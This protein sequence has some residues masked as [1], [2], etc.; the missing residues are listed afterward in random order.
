MTTEESYDHI[1]R[2][3]RGELTGEEKLLFEKELSTNTALAEGLRMHEDL[4]FS[5]DNNFR[6]TLLNIPY[7]SSDH[8]QPGSLPKTNWIQIWSLAASFLLI[9][10]LGLLIYQLNK[11]TDPNILYA[12]YFKPPIAL[13]PELSANRGASNPDGVPGSLEQYLYTADRYYM[14]GQYDEAIQ[15]LLSYPNNGNSQRIQFQL[16][17]L[18]LA[19]D[20]PADALIHFNK[21]TQY[22][23]ADN[24]WYKSLTLL[25]LN[26]M[27]EAKKELQTLVSNEKW[28]ASAI[29]LL[30][31]I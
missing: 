9:V 17:L 23:P 1:E 12:L 13:S 31:Q 14:A 3:L 29:K 28:G 6:N 16:G 4:K 27:D 7:L 18:Y 30:K 24:T 2:Y 22:S 8:S 19:V 11:K 21:V 5:L 26:R 25:K 15:A 20:R 10:S